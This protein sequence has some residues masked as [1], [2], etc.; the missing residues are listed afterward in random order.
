MNYGLLIK[1]NQITIPPT[2][3]MEIYIDQKIHLNCHHTHHL[4]LNL[5][6]VSGDNDKRV[7]IIGPHYQ[8]MTLTDD[9]VNARSLT[10]SDS[11][12]TTGTDII[13]M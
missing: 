11:A 7:N 5:N 2:S 13:I 6:I 1:L 8:T 4:K 12:K 10:H 3:E 9:D